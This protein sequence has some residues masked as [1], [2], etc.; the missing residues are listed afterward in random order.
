[1]SEE[2]DKYK[3]EEKT[4]T[5]CYKKLSLENSLVTSCKHFFC[6]KCFFRWFSQAS[7]NRYK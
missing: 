7:L 4:C 6:S 5:I 1:M 3:E 2:N